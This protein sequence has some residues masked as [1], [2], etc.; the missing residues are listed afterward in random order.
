MRGDG[1]VGPPLPEVV[2]GIR[3][4]L[5]ELAASSGPPALRAILSSRNVIYI[6]EKVIWFTYREGPDSVDGVVLT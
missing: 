1:S 4:L 6:R 3:G 2:V 5:E